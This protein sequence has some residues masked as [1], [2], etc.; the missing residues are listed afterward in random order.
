MKQKI[1]FIIALLISSFACHTAHAEEISFT[2][3]APNAVVIGETFR[4]S[5]TINTH[6]ARGFRIGDIADDKFVVHTKREFYNVTNRGKIMKSAVMDYDIQNVTYFQNRIAVI[7]Q[8]R[9]MLK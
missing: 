3:S 5:Y 4:L 1:L 6:D 9:M 7:G 2:A 8:D